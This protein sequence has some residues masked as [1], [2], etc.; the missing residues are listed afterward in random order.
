MQGG[1]QTCYDLWF[2][3]GA[4]TRTQEAELEV[5]ETKML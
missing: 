4:L 2:G 5:A 3:D 1:S